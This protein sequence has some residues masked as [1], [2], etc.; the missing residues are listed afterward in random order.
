MKRW[1]SN[2]LLVIFGAVFV[3]SAYLLIDYYIESS[4]QKEQFNALANLV[5]QARPQQPATQPQKAEST[6]QT[7][8]PNWD[9]PIIAPTDDSIHEELV[10]IND[11]DTGEQI[12][13][14]PEYADVYLMNTDLVGWMTI[15]GTIINYPVMHT[16]D[17]TDYYL[18]R[19]FNGNSS[20]AGCLYVREACDV[21]KPTDNI[22]IY[23]HKKNDGT[24]FAALHNYKKE[25]FWEEHRHITFDTLTEHH[26]Y[27]VMAVFLASASVGEDFDYHLFVDAQTEEQFNDFVSSCTELS[28]YETGVEAKYGDKL[29]T[30][31]TCDFGLTNGRLVVVAKRVS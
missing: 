10:P 21:N 29:I 17:R 16:P 5:Q 11:P 28:L 4:Q 2:V 27:E 23:G 15:E 19:D 9:G 8:D 22:T 20:T 13:V 7:V 26:T 3:V 31:V 14:L 18:H 30:L 24:M 1:L 25:S 6:Q 12:Y